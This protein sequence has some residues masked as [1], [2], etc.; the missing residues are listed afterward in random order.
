MPLL[1]LFNAHSVINDNYQ[2]T[3]IC[4][5]FRNHYTLITR[6]KKSL[7]Q[8][9]SRILIKSR[10]GFYGFDTGFDFAVPE[11]LFSPL[12]LRC[13]NPTATTPTARCIRPRRRDPL[14]PSRALRVQRTPHS[15]NKK[16]GF[17]CPFVLAEKE[18]CH[19]CAQL[20]RV[21]KTFSFFMIWRLSIRC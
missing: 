2:K 4:K 3:M 15:Q 19:S 9:D 7:N 8:I 13:K 20:Y 11:F 5:T 12:A 6:K 17:A 10:V 18:R 1:F 14:S 16:T 21:A